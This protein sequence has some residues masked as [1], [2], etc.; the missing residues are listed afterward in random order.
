M[1]SKF[2]TYQLLKILKWHQQGLS[3]NE[4]KILVQAKYSI[5]ISRARLY[6]LVKLIKQKLDK[7]TISTGRGKVPEPG[8]Q[9]GEVNSF[10]GIKGAEVNPHTLSSYVKGGEK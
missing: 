8:G 3:F 2:N 1:K 9:A 6:Q 7:R 4:I 10:S 5:K